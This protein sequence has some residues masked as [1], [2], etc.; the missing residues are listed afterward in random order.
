MKKEN[1]ARN[2]LDLNKINSYKCKA[3]QYSTFKINN[4][5]NKLNTARFINLDKRITNK[6]S[7][8]KLNGNHILNSPRI[9]NSKRLLLKSDLREKITK[10]DNKRPLTMRESL[11]NKTINNKVIEILTNKI[12]QI[13][14]YI[15]ESDKKNKNSISHI[16]MKKKVGRKKV[17]KDN[18]DIIG[19][20]Y[21]LTERVRNY[22]LSLN[23]EIS[24]K[25]KKIEKHEEQLKNNKN[26]IKLDK[27]PI[28][29][30]DT[31]KKTNT[32]QNK[33]INKT[34]KNNKI[35]NIRNKNNINNGNN[36]FSDTNYNINF[37]NCHFH[38]K[39]RSE[40]YQNIE[41]NTN[42]NNNDNI[43]INNNAELTKENKSI[44]LINNNVK[45]GSL[46]VFPIKQM[47]QNKIIVKGI[48][49][50][51]FEKL[52][53]K[54]YA[55]RNIDIPKAVTDRIK[56][57]NGNTSQ[58]SSNRFINTSNNNRKNLAKNKKIN[59]NFFKNV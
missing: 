28:K 51:G 24:D 50:N 17:L 56:N 46:K 44:I 43:S 42:I 14:E 3:S 29:N 32:S 4:S 58:N 49:I 59:T 45:I 8:K 26:I 48:K 6:S 37:N 55:T 36:Y 22:K 39:N 47:N 5:N 33:K 7:E 18:D 20:K 53:T 54:K 40:L 12:N 38:S 30:N 9:I 21:G 27:N 34:S 19:M 41:N 2:N 11:N 23:N 16:F 35:K 31:S 15:K 10:D 1:T 13:K 52:V 57:F 25:K